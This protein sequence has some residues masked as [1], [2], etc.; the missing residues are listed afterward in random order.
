[1]P[2]ST[3]AS[4]LAAARRKLNQVVDASAPAEGDVEQLRSAVLAVLTCSANK[5]S[6][7]EHTQADIQDI[8]HIA[9]VLWVRPSAC[10]E[11]MCKLQV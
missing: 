1:M 9:S 10:R 4:L 8:L 6:A 5:D 11:L 7:A 3:L 2:N